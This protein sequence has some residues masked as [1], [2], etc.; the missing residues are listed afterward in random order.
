MISTPPS[1]VG[2]MALPLVCPVTLIVLGAVDGSVSPRHAKRASGPPESEHAAN[3]TAS[4]ATGRA[5][6][7]RCMAQALNGFRKST[8]KQDVCALRFPAVLSPHDRKPHARRSVQRR[9][10]RDCDY[11]ADPRDPRATRRPRA[12]GGPRGAVAIVRRLSDELRGDPHHVGES[13]RAAAHG[14]GRHLSVSVHE[15]AAAAHGDV[16]PVSDRGPVL[17]RDIRG[18]RPRLEAVVRHDGAGRAQ[19]ERD[20]GNGRDRPQGVLLGPG[21]VSPVD[22][23]RADTADARLAR[24]RFAVDTLD[25]PGLQIGKERDSMRTL[26][27]FLTAAA[28]ALPLA[29]QDSSQPGSNPRREALIP[30]A[31]ATLASEYYSGYTDATTTLIDNA[32]EWQNA[33]A[34]LYATVSPK[35]DVPVVDFLNER[36]VLVSIGTRNSGG[37]AVHIDSLV[38]SDEG[39]R[40]FSTLTVPGSDC[41]VTEA[42]TQPVHAVRVPTPATPVTFS[43]QMV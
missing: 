19:A 14:G 12:V 2:E 10:V 27:R 18:E 32:F 28:V 23:R 26:V 35:P 3:Q 37:F 17:L 20:S 36:V 22:R 15:R 7:E 21:G 29:C 43:Q 42:L 5:E 6:I 4:N 39:T 9:C 30:D 38:T 40:V 16:R 34:R 41:G 11:A 1:A 24:Q 31:A 33:W 25:T 13:P 8:R